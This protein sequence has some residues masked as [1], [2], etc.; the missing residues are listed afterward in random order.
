[1]SDGETGITEEV[2]SGNTGGSSR[3]A[4]VSAGWRS[5]PGDE[6]ARQ[7]VKNGVDGDEKNVLLSAAAGSGKTKTLV[8]RI[9]E[10]ALNFREGRHIDSLAVVTFTRAA[11][12]ELAYKIENALSE[13]A[14]RLR[15]EGRSDDA[16]RLANEC[17]LLPKATIGTIDSLCMEIVRKNFAE[18]KS[19]RVDPNFDVDDDLVGIVRKDAAS[20]VLEKYYAAGADTPDG[21]IMRNLLAAFKEYR[22]DSALVDGLI[23]ICKFCDSLPDPYTWL[24]KAAGMFS[25][26]ED[27]RENEWYLKVKEEWLLEL[28]TA[29]EHAECIL[30]K[31]VEE[32]P[33]YGALLEEN[34]V[35][36]ENWFSN[37]AELIRNEEEGLTKDSGPVPALFAAGDPSKYFKNVST[38]FSNK[39]KAP[40]DVHAKDEAKKV[41]DLEKDVVKDAVKE[42]FDKFVKKFLASDDPGKNEK[43]FRTGIR[44]T[45]EY[46]S[47]IARIV[48][49]IYKK[50]VEDCAVRRSFSFAAVAHFALEILCGGGSVIGNE[51][52]MS[53]VPSEVAKA[54]RR[55]LDE[56]Y[57][58]E[59]QDT[60]MLQ[61]FILYQISGIQDG[62]NNMIMVG[63]IKQSIYSFRD[64]RPA[65]MLKKAQEYGKEGSDGVLML[66]S[67][68]FRSRRDIIDGVNEIFSRVMTAKAAD[69]DYKGTGQALVYGAVKRYENIPVRG[70]PLGGRCELIYSP[71]KGPESEAAVV[72]DK[73]K[74]LQKGF[75]V[76]ETLRDANGLPVRDDDGSEVSCQRAMRLGDICIIANKNKYLNEMAAWLQQAGLTTESRSS[77]YYFERSEIFDI[78]NFVRVIDNPRNDI[79]LAG[80]LLS[81]FFGFTDNELA[82]IKALSLERHPKERLDFWERLLD[83][84]DP[85]KENPYNSVE[86]SRA[87]VKAINDLRTAAET[88]PVSSFVW[89]LI[90]FR[91]YYKKHG[92]I[93]KGNLRAFLDL[94]YPFDKGINGG[95][96]GFAKK[97]D[98]DAA[99]D[100]LKQPFE[101]QISYTVASDSPDK[102]KLMT[103]HK[104]KG[105]EFPIVF[106][107]RT[108][109][110]FVSSTQTIKRDEKLGIGIEFQYEDGGRFKK[111]G[112]SAPN[113][114][115]EKKKAA[116]E[117]KEHQRLV[118]VALTRAKEKLFVVGSFK[119][120]DQNDE[121]K[122]FADMEPRCE[123]TTAS[124][125]RC[126]T[127]FQLVWLGCTGRESCWGKVICPQDRVM[128]LMEEH[129]GIAGPEDKEEIEETGAAP[130]PKTPAADVGG[131]TGEMPGEDRNTAPAK[132]EKT[133]GGDVAAAEDEDIRL[134]TEM[135]ETA[136]AG[137]M[138]VKISV[139]AL[140]RYVSEEEDSSGEG[141][142]F[143]LEAKQF[144]TEFGRTDAAENGKGKKGP[145]KLKGAALGTL[146]HKIMKLLI[147]DRSSWPDGDR[148]EYFDNFLKKLQQPGVDVL[149]DA[150]AAS[151]DKAMALNFLNSP[152]AEE[153][154]RAGGNV[155]CEVPFTYRTDLGKYLKYAKGAGASEDEK[156]G[157]GEASFKSSL[158]ETKRIALQGV[159]D[160]Y[161]KIDGKTVVVDFKTDNETAAADPKVLDAYLL[162]VRCYRD[163]LKDIS[164]EKIEKSLLFF[165]KNGKTA[166]LGEDD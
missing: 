61:E 24:D 38:V 10:K 18:V 116:E 143:N 146:M 74:E 68:N 150:E 113:I 90:N 124:I 154:R 163:A 49:D 54:Y 107:I 37:A 55:K 7:Y 17:Y 28:R 75:T 97:I 96:F 148:G 130:A 111:I 87:A 133:Q 93:A 88:I 78:L 118:Y 70:D 15:K 20:A 51:D 109:E 128:E 58:D 85:E 112:K 56:I 50:T 120:K 33:L 39:G 81:D 131:N 27:I 139:S 126:K 86:K 141:N 92:D 5:L 98:R 166:V 29:R 9:V 21:R 123:V 77:E 6:A 23:E 159:I 158:K 43:L 152:I 140:K 63:D 64:A 83:F 94:S 62:R 108:N 153:V 117:R 35:K 69:I 105:L 145:S 40:V 67:R 147:E 106:Y 161:Y 151:V 26:Q 122:G 32:R 115:M 156:S 82:E 80:L 76:Q 19:C 8:D 95:F 135:I 22:N 53:L 57:V 4:A 47:L 79:P 101:R 46:V 31:L 142:V 121:I 2:L 138:P 129:L 114:V 127:A 155:G 132:E 42:G 16:E 84:C 52:P 144:P 100:A 60:S 14:D 45:G 102:I 89:K 73:I 65:L 119:N 44:E 11:A 59:Y 91:D 12:A 72:I 162:Q 160:L 137:A 1:M 125:N 48:K 30:R 25:L 103:V 134:I 136:N 164:G 165:L 3:D 99:G 104:S 110:E 66:L 71:V 41:L 13:R 34:I 149:D 36:Y 157:D